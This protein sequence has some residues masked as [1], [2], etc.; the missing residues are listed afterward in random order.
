LFSAVILI[1]AKA[2][3]SFCGQLNRKGILRLRRAPSRALSGNTILLNGVFR[4]ANP[5]I[6]VPETSEEWKHRERLGSE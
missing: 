6:G 3:S 5:E 4:S 1:A 2:R